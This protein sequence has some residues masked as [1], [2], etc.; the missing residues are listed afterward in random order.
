MVVMM[1]GGQ[2]ARYKK[3]VKAGMIL[4][5]RTQIRCP[6]R[7]C[8]LR[9]WID[10]DSGQLEEHLLRRGFMREEGDFGRHHHHEEGDAGDIIIMKKEMPAD[11]II[12]K[13]EMMTE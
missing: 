6:C 2:V 10:P 4:N 13:K 3:D 1:R 11:M 8:K 7:K 12:M 9:T 5:N